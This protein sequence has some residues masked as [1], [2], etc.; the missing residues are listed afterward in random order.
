MQPDISSQENANQMTGLEQYQ[1]VR[2]TSLHQA[3][4]EY[5]G[6]RVNR[7]PPEIGDIGTLVDI[8][9]ADG[10]PDRFVVECCE[11]DGTTV[12]LSDFNADE[13]EP[14]SQKCHAHEKE[15]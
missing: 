15:Y 2:V 7:R 8:L 9:H 1:L 12:W 4:A 14:H 11:A 3:N 10:L 6:W 5:D 13:L